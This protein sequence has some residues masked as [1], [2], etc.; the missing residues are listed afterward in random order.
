MPK[1]VESRPKHSNLMPV[2][3]TAFSGTSDTASHTVSRR[4]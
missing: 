3:I 1:A 2:P 4:E